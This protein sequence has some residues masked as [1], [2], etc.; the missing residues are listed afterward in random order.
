MT[1]KISQIYEEE[2]INK[3]RNGRKIVLDNRMPNLQW[4]LEKRETMRKE[5]VQETHEIE[6]PSRIQEVIIYIVISIYSCILIIQNT[7]VQ[8]ANSTI[9]TAQELVTTTRDI[10]RTCWIRI[11]KEIQVK[12]KHPHAQ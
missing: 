10:S 4:D 11:Q 1:D 3:I 8:Y 5:E 6:T 9:E 7:V 2:Q 12:G